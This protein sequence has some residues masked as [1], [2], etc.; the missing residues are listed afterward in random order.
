MVG[1]AYVR[2]QIQDPVLALTASVTLREG[3]VR[4][5]HKKG[6]FSIDTIST[7][8]GGEVYDDETSY[9]Q[10]YMANLHEIDLLGGLAGGE[11]T[12]S[13]RLKAPESDWYP[14]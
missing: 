9:K 1:I 14:D 3:P 7:R 12:Q 8:T 5:G 13:V 6:N 4:A 11:H 10:D 2:T